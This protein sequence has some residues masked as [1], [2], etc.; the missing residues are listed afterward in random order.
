MREPQRTPARKRD[1]GLSGPNPAWSSASQDTG[2]QPAQWPEDP[3][4]SST[5]HTLRT[6]ATRTGTPV[7]VGLP[8]PPSTHVQLG[9]RPHGKGRP[10]AAGSPGFS[11]QNLSLE[12]HS[13]ERFCSLHVQELIQQRL[14]G[15]PQSSRPLVRILLLLQ[16]RQAAC[17]VSL[18]LLGNSGDIVLP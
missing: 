5:Q 9:P 7:D 12:L 10:S 8:A 16:T 11:C 14:K 2:K 4:L 18:S 3:R 13:I 17:S 1:S 6:Q 15:S